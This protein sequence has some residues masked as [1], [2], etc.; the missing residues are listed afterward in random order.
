LAVN[1][2]EMAMG[3]MRDGVPLSLLVDLA[4]LGV[5]SEELLREESGYDLDARHLGV[6]S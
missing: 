2:T 4:G 6:A 1:V 3:L 5:S